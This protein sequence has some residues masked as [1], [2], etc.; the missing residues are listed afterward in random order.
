MN[1][2][3]LIESLARALDGTLDR[4]E[5]RRL[6]RMLAERDNGRDLIAE[7]LEVDMALAALSR[8]YD[9]VPMPEDL[10]ERILRGVAV[11][12]VS[13]PIDTGA[14]H[15]ARLP[16]TLAALRAQRTGAAAESARPN[17]GHPA[18]AAVPLRWDGAGGDEGTGPIRVTLEKPG[19]A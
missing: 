5:R 18:T 16:E 1:D 17:G 8:C 10:L 7:A 6:F 3:D 4:V 12:P 19:A 2:A 11:T 13:E 15:W 9:A 14:G